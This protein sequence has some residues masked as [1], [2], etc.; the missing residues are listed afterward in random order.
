MICYLIDAEF[1]QTQCL[2]FNHLLLNFTD[3]N[4]VIQVG[5]WGTNFFK[6]LEW[7]NLGDFQTLCRAFG[8]QW[9]VIVGK[10]DG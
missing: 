4:S 2:K 3:Q 1:A 5:Q 9:I 8:T 7:D 10:M 6:K